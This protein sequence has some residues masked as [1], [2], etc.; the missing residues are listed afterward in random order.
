LLVKVAIRLAGCEGEI[1]EDLNSVIL[2]KALI[3]RA[4]LISKA[5]PELLVQPG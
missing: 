2:W 3:V 4:N 1:G 5:T